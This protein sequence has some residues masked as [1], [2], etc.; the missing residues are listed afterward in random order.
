MHSNINEIKLAT[1]NR[2]KLA[3]L[4][5]SFGEEL[6]VKLSLVPEFDCEETGSSFL[7]NATQ[8]A[9]RASKITSSWCLA[10]DSGLSVIAMNSAP[11]IYSARFFEGGKGIDQI[12][13]SLA[14]RSDRQAYYTCALVLT[15]SDAQV[16]W[17]TEKI[18]NGEIASMPRGSQG[19]GYD[20]I[21]IP[22]G[23][24]QT[25]AELNPSLKNKISHRAQAIQALKE[26]LQVGD[27]K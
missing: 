25:V 17:Y 10:D 24:Q 21:F 20:P 1:S 23:Y 18:W 6:E 3:E 12:L 5:A 9:Q 15:D 27:R 13:L 8:K 11:G 14:K 22:H 19:F 26:F 16:H 4:K 2:H 7:A